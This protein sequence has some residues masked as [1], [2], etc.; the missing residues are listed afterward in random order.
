MG[1][2]SDGFLAVEIIRWILLVDNEIAEDMATLL[3][4]QI[5]LYC[6]GTAI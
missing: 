3:K 5:Q 1:R 6:S 4:A 2:K